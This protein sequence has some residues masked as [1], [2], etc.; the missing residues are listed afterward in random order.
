MDI[1]SSKIDVKSINVLIAR[2]LE[3]QGNEKSYKQF[4]EEANVDTGADVQGLNLIE[5]LD[6]YCELKMML[7]SS[8]S[9]SSNCSVSLTEVFQGVEEDS[10]QGEIITKVESKSVCLCTSFVNDC[11]YWADSAKTFHQTDLQGNEKWS[12][13]MLEH[14]SI[15][16]V[17]QC[18]Q[19]LVVCGTQSGKVRLFVVFVFFG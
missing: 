14:G 12:Q 11:V 1:F 9:P 3:S 2:Y 16:C 17:A 7:K 13:M 19:D 15:L 10:L 8:S 4:V 6:E 18:G 5:M